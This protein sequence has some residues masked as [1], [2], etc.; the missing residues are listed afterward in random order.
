VHHLGID[1]EDVV[2]ADGDRLRVAAHHRGA[3]LEDADDE[4]VVG[5]RREGVIAIFGRQAGDA[6]EHRHPGE[7]GVLDVS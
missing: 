5:V 2:G 6:A 4:G 7:L 3:R 1:D